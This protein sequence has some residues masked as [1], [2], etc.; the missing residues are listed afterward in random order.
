VLRR[1]YG[2]PAFGVALTAIG[3]IC[4]VSAWAEPV[5]GEYPGVKQT[6][7]LPQARSNGYQC[8]DDVDSDLAATEHE[9]RACKALKQMGP[10]KFLPTARPTSTKSSLFIKDSDFLAACV[11]DPAQTQPGWWCN[12]FVEGIA[13]LLSSGRPPKACIPD[14]AGSGELVDVATSYLKTHPP[15]GDT[16]AAEQ[17]AIALSKAWPCR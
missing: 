5:S 7:S 3:F 2:R 9:K 17:V 6:T 12:G 14:S 10:P 11:P 1:H 13:D 16:N 15:H 4:A 8:P